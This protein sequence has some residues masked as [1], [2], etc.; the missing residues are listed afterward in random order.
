MREKMTYLF[1]AAVKRSSYS[2]HAASNLAAVESAALQAAG[3]STAQV[4]GRTT[5]LSEAVNRLEKDAQVYLWEQSSQPQTWTKDLLEPIEQA[6]T[7]AEIARANQDEF[8]LAAE[9]QAYAGWRNGWFQQEV[10]GE[11]MDTTIAANVGYQVLT[12]FESIVPHGSITLGNSEPP[13][14]G[15]I[16]AVLVNEA[17]L[18]A[19]RNVNPIARIS[20]QADDLSGLSANL[21]AQDAIELAY[22]T[23]G[24]NLLVQERYQISSSLLN[25]SGGLLAL[26][27]LQNNLLLSAT[28][29]LVNDLVQLNAGRGIVAGVGGALAFR[30]VKL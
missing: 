12:S 17:A 24:Q 28:A 18:E 19:N 21:R 10:I 6:L 4:D 3:L 9:S 30:R 14:G 13:A 27:Y 7:K 16:V 15:A 22:P 20:G 1:V 11:Q 29:E 2:T 23:A 25:P 26:G 8:A 5:S